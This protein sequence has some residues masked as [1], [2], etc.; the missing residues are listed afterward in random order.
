MCGSTGWVLA[1]PCVVIAL[2]C[3]RAAVPGVT[4]ACHAH[5]LDI[6][7]PCPCRLQI[8]DATRLKQL[9]QWKRLIVDWHA[10]RKATVMTVAGFPL[11]E[12]KAIG[13]AFPGQ[14]LASVSAPALDTPP[15][16]V[17]CAGS[18]ADTSLTL[19][20]N[21]WATAPQ[22]NST[23]RQPTWCSTM[24]SRRVRG[25][26]CCTCERVRAAADPTSTRACMCA[27]L[28][29]LAPGDLWVGLLVVPR[30]RRV[31]GWHTKADSH[32][33]PVAAGLGWRDI[34]LR[35][36]ACAVAG[37]HLCCRRATVLRPAIASE[38]R[39]GG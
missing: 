9:E 33:L 23:R 39:A 16:A 14:P 25:R 10:A 35:A 29:W 2:G 36:L 3:V 28:A 12:N 22:G 30:S 38:R 13:R 26:P 19:P 24:S 37:A 4:S 32:L 27:A 31:G 1:L 5:A 20:R 8:V 34:R 17:S 11:F 21:P 6:N 7:C 18:C 15:R